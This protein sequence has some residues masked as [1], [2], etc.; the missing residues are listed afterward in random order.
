M[1]AE[2]ATKAHL[3][4][5]QRLTALEATALHGC[6]HLASLVHTLRA[7]GFVVKSKS[8]TYAAVI[9]RLRKGGVILDPPP[10]L[11]IR[12]ITFTE[13]WVGR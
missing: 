8:I 5:G 12:E 9:E 4:A 13:Y 10:N 6:V 3:L 1:N 11:P 2:N 7:D